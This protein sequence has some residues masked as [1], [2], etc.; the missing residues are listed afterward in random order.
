MG[1]AA[2]VAVPNYR[3]VGPY[4]I[5]LYAAMLCL[6]VFLLIPFVP[7]SIVRARGGAR[8]WI[9]LGPLDLQPSE[10]M[11]VAYILLLAWYLRY[12]KNHR[13]LKGLLWPAAITAVPMG[14]IMLQPD[15]GTAVLFIP[16]LFFVLI[17]AGAKLKHL[18]LAVLIA[19][20][21]APAVYP[22]LKPH[23]QQRIV[24][25]LL[26]V[27]GDAREDMDINMQP[28]TSKR[29]TGAGGLFG[30]SETETRALHHFNALPERHNDM[31]FAPVVTRFGFVGGIAVIGLCVAWCVGALLTAGVCGSPFGRL[32]CV[33]A[34]GF[35][36]AQTVINIGMSM[37]MVPIIGITL[38][39][40]SHGGSSMI[41][42]WL[43]SGLV[44]SAAL[45]RGGYEM[46]QRLNFE[47]AE[48]E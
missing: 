26:Q 36:F 25:L 28:V 2:A 22:V 42:Q 44:L 15:L 5:V 6:L 11:K 17:A 4:A 43:M 35:F 3:R 10:L 8:A 33:G 16:A 41:A 7:S 48:L 12:K 13:T 23:Q 39:F 32:A 1:I 38:P 21:G 30:R 18:S 14:L 20:L 24:G 29:L 19:M 40:V 34:V 47:D 27:R 46:G 9:D 37:G 31:V 45:H